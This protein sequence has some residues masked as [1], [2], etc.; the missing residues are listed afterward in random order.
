MKRTS[1]ILLALMIGILLALC[2]FGLAEG[3]WIRHTLAQG[4]LPESYSFLGMQLN[5]FLSPWVLASFL[6]AGIL[7]GLK[8]GFW[9]WRV[10]YI[11]HRHWRHK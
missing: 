11:E 2:A 3:W 4:L 1:Y 10:V 9:G 5:M 8:L 7:S 6:L